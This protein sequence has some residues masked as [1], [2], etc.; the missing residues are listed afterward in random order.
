MQLAQ[1]SLWCRGWARTCGDSTPQK[2]GG[3]GVWL[4]AS[5]SRSRRL[6][7][8]AS[9]RQRREGEVIIAALDEQRLA[10]EFLDLFS[11][12]HLSTCSCI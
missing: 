10:T 5:P 3:G 6:A 1:A 9:S 2:L 4:R 12:I 8:L 11:Y 7:L